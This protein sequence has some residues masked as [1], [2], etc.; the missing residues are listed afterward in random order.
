MHPGMTLG[1]AIADKTNAELSIIE[2][3]VGRL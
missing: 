3:A 1:K 2:V